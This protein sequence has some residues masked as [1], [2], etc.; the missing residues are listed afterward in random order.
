MRRHAT[1][2]VVTDGLSAEVLETLFVESAPTVESAV[3]EAL[4]RYGADAKVAV[5]PKGPYVL[6]RG[7]GGQ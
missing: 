2:K 1:V 3:E 6:A 4:E 7:P 5:I